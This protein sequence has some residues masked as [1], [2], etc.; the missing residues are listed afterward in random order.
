MNE[1]DLI[2]K[3]PEIICEKCAID[4]IASR[5][6]TKESLIFITVHHLP[7]RPALIEQDE[8]EL[9]S[10]YLQIFRGKAIHINQ[11]SL[12]ECTGRGHNVQFSI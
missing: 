12:L 5:T 10:H 3:R 9:V 4:H 2:K 8:R 6:R 7:C 11:N 1:R